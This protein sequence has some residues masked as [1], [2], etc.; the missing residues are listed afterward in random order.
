MAI[1]VGL[2]VLTFTGI[3]GAEIIWQIEKK[4]LLLSQK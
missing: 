1:S 2:A 4:R 3:I